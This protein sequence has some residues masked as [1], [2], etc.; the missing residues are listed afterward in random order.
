MAL[1]T[2]SN[3]QLAEQQV[4]LDSVWQQPQFQKSYTPRT[5]SLKAI[6]EQQTAQLQLL[7]DPNMEYDVGVIAE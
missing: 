4:A 5:D 2:F 1:T 7:E 6:L 3:V